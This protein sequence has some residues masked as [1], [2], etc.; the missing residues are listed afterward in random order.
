MNVELSKTPWELPT[1]RVHWD[2][3][4]WASTGGGGAAHGGD[5][6][7]GAESGASQRRAA[8]SPASEENHC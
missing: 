3:D 4:E 8:L 7:G 2:G 5:T 1:G 6:T